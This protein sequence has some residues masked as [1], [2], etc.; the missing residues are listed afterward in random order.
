M[1][2][3]LPR[4]LRSLRPMA[5]AG[6][7]AAALAGPGAPAARSQEKSTPVGEVERL[8]RAPVNKEGLLVQLP[9]PTVVK[10]P[11]GLTLLLLEDHK[12]PTVAFA[13]WIRPGQLADPID[14]P[15]LAAFAA[16]MLREGTERRTS[17]QIAAEVDSLGA[18][19]TSNSRFGMS[20]TVINASGLA[21]N[22]TQVLDL[23]SDIVLHPVFSPSELAKYKQR[24]RAN[25]E[26]R[27]S[28]PGFLAQQTFR[29]ALYG[30]GPLS[31]V[32]PTKESIEKVTSAD[33]K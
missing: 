32:S 1:K 15:G 5:F 13:M 9:R 12:L 17:L 8:N 23:L 25:I 27:L 28:N 10:L 24:E 22:A 3:L 14:L 4:S 26:E 16:D 21:D 30:D 6:L 33:L 18:T 29:R 31:V 7:A 2:T 19:L 11:N 20:Y